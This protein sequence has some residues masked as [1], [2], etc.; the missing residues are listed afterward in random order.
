[1]TNALRKL[2]LFTLGL[3]IT[4]PV[5]A[6]DA[7]KPFSL[8]VNV[9]LVELHVTVVDGKQRPI[10][11]LLQENFRILENKVEQPIAVFKQEDI[12]ISL[13]LILDNS[14][15]IEPRKERLDAAALSFVRKSN[16][17]DETFVVH[18]DFEARLSQDFSKDS[19]QLRT[20]LTREKPYGQTAIYDAISLALDTMGRA[21]YD[22]KAM[23]LVTDGIDNHSVIPYPQ[24][25]EKVKRSNVAIYVVG[26]LSVSGGIVAEDTLIEI[27]EASGGRAYFPQTSEQASGMMEGIARDLREQYTLGYFPTNPLRDGEWRSVRVELTPP[28]GVPSNLD[29]TYRRGYYAP[30]QMLNER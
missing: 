20:T 24:L 2:R 8:S 26:L 1:M 22:K 23:L 19:H 30:A 14:R 21:K 12:P 25:I 27:A 9:D 11:G 4:T 17:E 16:P 18:F 7:S 10:G 3:L 29:L 6:Q 15:S 13:G 28:K 5:V